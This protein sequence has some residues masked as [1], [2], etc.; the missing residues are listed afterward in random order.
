METPPWQA[1]GR[2]GQ[3]TLCSTKRTQGQQGHRTGDASLV[4]SLVKGV[5]TKRGLK[6]CLRKPAFLKEDTVL[7]FEHEPWQA[8]L[9]IRH[10]KL[11][12]LSTTLVLWPA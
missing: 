6:A 2:R 10:S 1:P 7:Y 8:R 12:E 3:T 9:L 4:R 5:K 11:A